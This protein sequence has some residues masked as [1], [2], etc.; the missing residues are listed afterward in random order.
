MFSVLIRKKLFVSP[1]HAAS[2]PAE[3]E[4]RLRSGKKL[5]GIWEHGDHGRPTLRWK[6]LG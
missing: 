3:G 5:A 6:A 2:R 1:V 4:P